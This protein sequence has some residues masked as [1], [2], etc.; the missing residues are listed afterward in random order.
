MGRVSEKY[1]IKMS[2]VANRKAIVQGDKYRFTVLT[3]Q[4]IRLEYDE[5]G[6]FEDRA[7]Q[8]VLN[9]NYPV[10]EF[11]VVEKPILWRLLQVNSIWFMIK[12]VQQADWY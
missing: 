5:A 9:R 11:R 12:N 4:L 2:P 8:V 1:K 7:T 6:I 10:P 3:P